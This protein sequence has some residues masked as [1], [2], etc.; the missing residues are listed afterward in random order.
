MHVCFETDLLKARGQRGTPVVSV[1]ACLWT[2]CFSSVQHRKSAFLQDGERR[3]EH[4]KQ[5]TVHYWCSGCTVQGLHRASG[6]L[7]D[8]CLRTWHGEIM[9]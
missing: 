7:N 2:I 9:P 8:Q 5:R 6:P 1:H 4:A 3:Q